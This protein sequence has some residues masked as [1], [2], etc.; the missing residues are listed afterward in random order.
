[1]RFLDWVAAII[2]FFQFPI[3]LFWLILHPHIAFWRRHLKAGYWFAG[4]TAWGVMI[5]VLFR[6]LRASRR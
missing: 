1:M 5:P 2:L 6:M 4:L 3:P